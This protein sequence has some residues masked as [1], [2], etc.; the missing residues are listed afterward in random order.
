M[1]LPFS[2][3]YDKKLFFA[4]T[5]RANA[6][7]RQQKWLYYLMWM[8]LGAVLISAGKTYLAERRLQPIALHLALAALLAAALW[9]QYMPS[10]LAARK[11]W[12]NPSIRREW[13]GEITDSG[14][15]YRLP[16]GEKRYSWKEIRRIRMSRNF[17]S[18][19]TTQGMLLIFP[20][21]FFHR[22]KDWARFRAFLQKKIP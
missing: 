8:V 22:E 15:L 1:K 13:K 12:K 9:Q 18:L 5:Q 11:M 6:P 19:V 21:R 4:A 3:S 20:R 2:G 7:A 16:E 14:I 17:V 10:W